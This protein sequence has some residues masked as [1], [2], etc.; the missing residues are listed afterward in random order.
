[1]LL[2]LRYGIFHQPGFDSDGAYARARP[3]CY[4]L[5]TDQTC[6]NTSRVIGDVTSYRMEQRLSD[7]TG[8]INGT[9]YLA[10]C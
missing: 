6:G 4:S 2:F 7:G 9:G 1:M 10:C 5:N 3:G 8:Y